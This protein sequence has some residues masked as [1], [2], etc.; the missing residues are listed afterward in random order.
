[1]YNGYFC[2]HAGELR[3]AGRTAVALE[4]LVLQTHLKMKTSCTALIHCT[5]AGWYMPGRGIFQ[6]DHE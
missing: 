4:H 6:P 2:L 5:A 1:M 3:R